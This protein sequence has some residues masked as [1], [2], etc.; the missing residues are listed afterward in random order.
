MYIRKH[1]VPVLVETGNYLAEPFE[2][3]C[4]AL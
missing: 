1:L 2:V 3:P 4:Y